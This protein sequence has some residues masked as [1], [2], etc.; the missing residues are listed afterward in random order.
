[1]KVENHLVIVLVNYFKDDE[2]IHFIS[3]QLDKQTL[4]SFMLYVVNNGSQDEKKLSGF[5]NH[6]S[7]TV[8]LSPGRNLGY[9]GGFNFALDQQ[10]KVDG[11][12]ELMILCN[13]DIQFD[14]THFL[15]RLYS[16]YGQTEF[17]IIGTS[18]I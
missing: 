4:N 12:P 16:M 8:L 13:T 5:C 6:R 14:N 17:G 18:V 15:E 11:F 10:V 2:V 9:L 7:E 1:M 3:S